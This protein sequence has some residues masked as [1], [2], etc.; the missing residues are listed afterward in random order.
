MKNIGI[1]LG[2]ILSV[3]LLS[4]IYNT[5]SSES[6][7]NTIEV[8]KYIIGIINSDSLALGESLNHAA[9]F[10]DTT[11]L[12]IRDKDKEEYLFPFGLSTKL[13][14]DRLRCYTKFSA[15][16][17]QETLAF[18]DNI[19]VSY[20]YTVKQIKNNNLS[21]DALKLKIKSKINFF[22]LKD[23]SFCLYPLDNEKYISQ[24]FNYGDYL[25]QLYLNLENP[26]N[27]YILYISAKYVD[28]YILDQVKN[29]II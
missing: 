20:E 13:S 7:E 21:L 19:L 1:S 17:E 3:L 25:I 22:E 26:S 18:L 28:S 16:S 12:W 2:S 23:V 27:E 4:C 9:H 10:F 5:K 6:N 15:P 24:E 8:N 14:L 29:E 11:A